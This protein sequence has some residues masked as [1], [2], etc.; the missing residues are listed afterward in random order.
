MEG[1]FV[2]LALLLVFLPLALAEPLNYF[3]DANGNGLVDMPD[4]VALE[5]IIAGGDY[6]CVPIS[7]CKTLDLSGNGIIDLP[8]YTAMQY[9][10]SGGTPSV[11]L[12]EN[13]TIL[14]VTN[15]TIVLQLLNCNNMPIA[16]ITVL[17]SNN[18]NVTITPEYNYTNSSGIVVFNYSINN[19]GN[20]TIVFY[21]L[22]SKL[23]KI[24]I[25][26]VNTTYTFVLEKPKE[27]KKEQPPSGGGGGGGRLVRKK[28][29]IPRWVCLNWSRCYSSGFQSRVCYD[30][31]RCNE[32]NKTYL[33]KRKC[34]VEENVT[35]VTE[36]KPAEEHEELICK[37]GECVPAEEEECKTCEYLREHGK[38]RGEYI[39]I[40]IGVL[41]IIYGTYRII[42]E[43]KRKKKIKEI[44]KD[45]EE[46]GGDKNGYK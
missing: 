35:P 45:M 38:I 23:G 42:K 37:E 2:V 14:N 34:K 12:P 11:C 27:E 9:L 3:G 5:H 43:R 21:T 7:D 29:C 31:N 25:T 18:S 17:H 32:T 46:N 15:N 33:E 22:A 8:D 16:G 30:T 1:K 39:L 10:I 26:S 41:L 24:N 20:H 28:E 36:E 6:N 19:Y 40:G 13:L 4:Y 44:A